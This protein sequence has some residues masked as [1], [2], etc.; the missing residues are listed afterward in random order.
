[1]IAANIL[2]MEGDLE[3]ASLEREA[4]EMIDG[5]L[6]LLES[7]HG[8]KPVAFANTLARLH[9][10]FALLHSFKGREQLPHNVRSVALLPV[11]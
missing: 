10:D 2:C 5:I 4:M 11:L 8:N 3:K 1:M 6:G 7:G 9:D